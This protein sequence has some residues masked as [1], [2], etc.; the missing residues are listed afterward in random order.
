MQVWIPE[1]RLVR[2]RD[3]AVPP[4]ITVVCPP[5]TGNV[6]IPLDGVIAVCV[7]SPAWYDS[8][9]ENAEPAVVT[10]VFVAVTPARPLVMLD[11]L[12]PPIPLVTILSPDPV[13]VVTLLPLML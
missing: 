7:A 2:A 9:S 1:L 12:R 3:P 6:A 5:N 13:E 11:R 10:V 4:E 8:L